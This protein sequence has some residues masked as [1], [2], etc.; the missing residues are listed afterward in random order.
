M[1][2]SMNIDNQVISI[3]FKYLKFLKDKTYEIANDKKI[4]LINP[5]VL[6]K[7]L[8]ISNEFFKFK[9]K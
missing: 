8:S 5:I 3:G 2:T 7:E 6:L 1:L 9:N 4:N